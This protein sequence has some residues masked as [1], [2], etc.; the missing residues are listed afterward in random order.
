MRMNRIDGS[1]N[2]AATAIAPPW[3]KTSMTKP[4]IIGKN[5]DIATL[6][7]FFN[8]AGPDARIRAR[9]SGGVTELYVR[10]MSVSG[11]L[12]EW[13]LTKGEDRKNAYHAAKNLI[14]ECADKVFVADNPKHFVGL[15]GVKDSVNRHQHDFRAKELG[16]NI[17]QFRNAAPLSGAR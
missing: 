7:D 8:R 9:T 17:E 2:Q 13:F 15:V 11:R 12:K 16:E 6:A 3:E 1:S 10:D 14:L 4:L 5:T